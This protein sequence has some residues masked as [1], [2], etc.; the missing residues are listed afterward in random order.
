VT[1][2]PSNGK[3]ILFTDIVNLDTRPMMKGRRRYMPNYSL[4][5]T[6]EQF[7]AE[8]VAAGDYNNASEVV[9]EA[10]RMLQYRELRLA[11]LDASIARG[12]AEADRGERRDAEEVFDRLEQKYRGMAEAAKE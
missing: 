6:L 8:K 10:L 5:K 4:T 11:S 9:R 1:P 2:E 3:I 7:V 12:V